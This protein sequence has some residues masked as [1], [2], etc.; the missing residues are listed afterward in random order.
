VAKD[1]LPRALA[2]TGGIEIDSG[3]PSQCPGRWYNRVVQA[4]ARRL[5]Q[6]GVNVDLC[7]QFYLPTLKGSLIALLLR[8]GAA[9]MAF[10]TAFLLLFS[11]LSADVQIG[12]RWV[13]VWGAS[14]SVT[15]ESITLNNHTVRQFAL[16]AIGGRG[17]RLRVQLTNELGAEE[18]LVRAAHIA[19][20]SSFG[21]IVPNSDRTLTVSGRQSFVIPAG[22]P[23]VSDPVDFDLG[24]S[25]PN[26]WIVAVSLYLPYSTTV[27][28]LHPNGWQTAYIMDGDRTGATNLSSVS[29]TTQS[30][31]FLSR[32]DA[33]AAPGAI[34]TL[35]D[36][37]TD[38][39]GSTPDA[40]GRWPDVLA[41]RLADAGCSACLP[42]AFV[43]NKGISGNR[44]LGN[45]GGPSALARFDRDVLSTPGGRYVILLEGIN[46]IGRNDE[47]GVTADDLITGYRQL[48]SRAHSKG[49]YIFGGTLTPFHGSVYDPLAPPRSDRELMRQTVNNWIRSSGEFDAVI[50][51][52]AA[53]RDPAAPT[54]LL[55]T[56]DSGDHIHPSDAGYS[57]MANAVNLNL[58]GL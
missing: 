10:A 56:Y 1:S 18:V 15:S 54:Q 53:V 44:L 55:G 28:T 45:D 36:S 7:Q 13:A 48:I 26:L 14:P 57:A 52:D 6:P 27:E 22:A 16:V 19:L 3:K 8:A 32:I 20:A 21:S 38:G 47:T 34:V 31:F 58:F 30:R 9:I 39:D 42:A 43:V 40:N 50:D 51:F 49:L 2:V 23:L 24:A 4:L 25:L 11:P 12:D 35:G 46:D 33:A 5:K 29:A 17:Q 41:R 37:I